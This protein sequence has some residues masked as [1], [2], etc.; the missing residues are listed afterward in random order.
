MMIK[1]LFTIGLLLIYARIMG[2]TTLSSTENSS[3]TTSVSTMSSQATTSL[4]SITTT[5]L[6]SSPTP[7]TK[8]SK[9]I[10]KTTWQGNMHSSPYINTTATTLAGG[11][12]VLKPMSNTHSLCLC[13]VL[14]LLCI[15]RQT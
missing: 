13:S 14:T 9:L 10:S 3:L 8:S 5:Q 15:L 4:S 7:E 6:G 12:T 1:H 11:G 2:T